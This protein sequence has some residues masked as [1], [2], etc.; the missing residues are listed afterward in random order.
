MGAGDDAVTIGRRLRQ[1]RCARGKTLVVVAGLAGI[2]ESHLSRLE[3]GQRALNRR[4]L[5]EA[6][7]NALEIAPSELTTRPVSGRPVMR[8]H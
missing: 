8:D 6:L 5:I 2:S 4:S 7:A 3:R 1:A